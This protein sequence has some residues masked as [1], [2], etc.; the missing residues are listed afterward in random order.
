MDF[1]FQFDHPYVHIR[2]VKEFRFREIILPTGMGGSGHESL[3]GSH[4]DGD[5]N[6][7]ENLIIVSDRIGPSNKGH[8]F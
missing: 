5:V 7:V 8:S 1:S 4:D 3:H 2:R 6:S